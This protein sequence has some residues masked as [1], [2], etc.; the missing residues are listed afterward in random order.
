MKV[1]GVI[2]ETSALAKQKRLPTGYLDAKQDITTA[3]DCAN[4]LNGN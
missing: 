2:D 3:V 4:V 1:F